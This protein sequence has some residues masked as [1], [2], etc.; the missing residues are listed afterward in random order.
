MIGIKNAEFY[1]GFKN[2]NL[3][4]RQNAPKKVILKNMLNIR[5]SPKT[6]GIFG[7]TLYRCI[8]TLR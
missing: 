1:A 6:A 2:T 8:F 5:L 3:P 4:L 7:I